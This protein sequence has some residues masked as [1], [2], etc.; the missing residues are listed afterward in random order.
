MRKRPQHEMR[1]IHRED[2]EAV[3]RGSGKRGPAGAEIMTE[4]PTVRPTVCAGPG[5]LTSVAPLSFAAFTEVYYRNALLAP[6][7]S[8]RRK[9]GEEKQASFA[10]ETP[11]QPSFLSLLKSLTHRNKDRSSQSQLSISRFASFV[12][13]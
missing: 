12:Y 8:C 13:Y 3:V 6:W 4:L 10:K 9:R 5:C 7:V 1:P 11:H 2:I